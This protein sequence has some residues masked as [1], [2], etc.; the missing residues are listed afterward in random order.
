MP[1]HNVRTAGTFIFVGGWATILRLLR[2]ECSLR[3]REGAWQPDADE[4]AGSF[5]DGAAFHGSK[6]YN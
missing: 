2:A 5:R 6:V 4:S 3:R 1:W